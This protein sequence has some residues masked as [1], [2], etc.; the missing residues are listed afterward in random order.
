MQTLLQD[1]RYGLRMLAKNPGFTVV[2]VVTLALGIGA[3][4]A[5]FSVVNTVLLRPLPYKEAD[6]LVTVWGKNL[7][8]GYDFDLVSPPDFADWRAQNRVFEEMAASDDAMYTLT[9]TGE[10]T[11]ITA[12]KFSAGFFHVLGV[13]PIIGR[14]FLPEEEQP[15]KNRVV[16]LSYRL[17][18]SRFGG[19][20]GVIEKMVRLNGEPYTVIGI[21]PPSFEYPQDTELWTPLRVEPNLANNRG[22]RF[23]RVLARLKPGVRI[24]EAEA[25]M[26]TIA[27]RLEREYPDT[28]KGEGVYL[29]TLRDMKVGDIRPALLVLLGAV[30]FV[31]LIACANVANLLLAR[32]TARQ[33]EIAIRG[34]LGASRVRMVRQFLT[35]S[36][37]LAVLGGGLG[38][39]LASWG[40]GGLVAM[41]PP[42]I[43]NL[44]IPRVDTIPIDDKVLGFALC[45]SLLTGVIFG[46]APA[47]EA[48]RLN[49]NESLK[50][51]GRSLASSAQG[52]RFRS[53]LVVSEVALSLIL[54]SA[55]GLLMKSFLHL[56]QG[57][58]GFDSNHVLTLRVWLPQYKYKTDP[59]QR[60]F[61]S[62][63]VEKIRSLPGVQSVGAV[64][65][66]PLSG[67]WGQR[68][69]TIEGRP[70]SPQNPQP[71]VV[72]S[73][74]TTDYFRTLGIPLVKGRFFS[75]R[76]I[77]EAPG[78]AIISKG[79]A[80]QFWPTED[81][82]GKRITLEGQ[83]SPR[84]IVGVVGDVRQ[85][86]LVSE[87]RPEIYI[88]FDQATTPLI[89]F[90]VRTASDP[91]NLANAVRHEVWAVDKDQA[92]SHVM[93]M[94][95][96]AAESLAPQ[97]I[98]LL[99]I[100]I[101]AA[102]ALILAAVGLYGVLAYSVT[103]R[104]HEVGI[105]MALGAGAGDV[106]KLVVGQ[107]LIL[108]LLGVA[109]GLAASFGLTRFLSSLLYGVRPTDPATFAGVSLLL[110]GVALAASYIPARR[111]TKVDP[112]VAL[113][114]E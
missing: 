41:F 8:K 47:F 33:R 25:E 50:E 78:V 112:M 71:A 80:R 92:V 49:P 29:K 23:L 17:W 5:V 7:E 34:A 73:S 55:A 83:R 59:Q 75:G 6:R 67:W 111:A 24:K 101:F 22:V 15:G 62:Q 61:S 48:C 18:Q 39:L 74:V 87:P 98:S 43:S 51:A 58:L 69:F 86:G 12:Y 10:P 104:T 108:T 60:A 109:I 56:L 70:V 90:A 107:G 11:S 93:T 106:L 26:N 9:G 113:R 1:I 95:Q 32:A 44:N 57:D 36:V 66:L 13:P 110:T 20:R 91:I 28:N 100:A 77:D 94:E 52:R 88:P 38:L 27:S 14:T 40:V 82:I 35:E 81:P 64:T 84:E 19:D 3:N 103:Q 65:F 85:F 54:L 102:L 114:Y 99:L 30:S 45:A 16:V 21:M 89:C 2:A 42:T 53:A 4:T 105:R 76:D 46:L 79:L 31:L 96:L 63:V 37:L 68:G 97:R 72:W